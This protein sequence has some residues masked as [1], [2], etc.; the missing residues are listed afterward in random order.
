[1]AL[2]TGID[3]SVID[4]AAAATDKARVQLLLDALPDPTVQPAKL[5]LGIL[6]YLDEINPIALVELRAHLEAMKATI[7]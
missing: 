3:V 7:T 6:S 5:P 4:Y 1:M 2:S